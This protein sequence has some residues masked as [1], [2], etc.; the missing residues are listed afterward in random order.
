MGDH[1]RTGYDNA[2]AFNT[3][4][5]TGIGMLARQFLLDEPDAPL[6]QQA[7]DY[8]PGYAEKNWGDLHHRQESDFYAWYNCS[9]G[10]FQA[11]GEPWNRWNQ[12][13]RDEL[14]RLQRHDGCARGSWDPK[15]K[16]GEQG[17]RILSTALA[18][19]TLEVYYRYAGHNEGRG[20]AAPVVATVETIPPASASK[21]VEL[22]AP[23]KPVE[24]NAPDK[25]VEVKASDKS[26][27][28]NAPDGPAKPKKQ[29]PT[30]GENRP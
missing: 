5:T 1:G 4:A 16:W 27:E 12:V 3:E 22:N 2:H 8:L 6:V 15:C 28:L 9:L 14:I 29:L 17:G 20:A 7:A 19:L 24:L 13:I 11:G 21:P 23:D 30:I 26:V 18:A 25:T 10:M